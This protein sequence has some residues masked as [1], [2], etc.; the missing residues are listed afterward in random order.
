[1]G[2]LDPT[3]ALQFLRLIQEAVTNA[4]AHSS[5]KEIT[6]FCAPADRSIYKPSSIWAGRLRD[7]PISL[8]IREWGQFLETV[9]N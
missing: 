2:W 5:A 8:N 7:W 6:F 9:P 3:N 1:L 4:I